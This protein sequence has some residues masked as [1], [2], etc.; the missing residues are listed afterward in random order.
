MTF[1]KKIEI[2]KPS[3]TI[4]HHDG[5]VFLGS[6]FAENIGNLFLANKF[7]T[8]VN[9]FGVLY[10]P[11]SISQAIDILLD[12]RVFTEADIFKNQGVY[13]TFFHHSEFCSPHPDQFLEKINQSAIQSASDLRSANVLFITFGTSYVY[14]LIESGMIVSNCHK[15]AASHFDRYRLS[16]EDIVADW[17]RV[18][19]RLFS[20]NPDLEI[21]MTV[22]PVRH[23]KDGAH[24]NQLS[25]SILLLAIEELL[26]IYSN[27]QYFPAYEIVLDELRDYRFYA[28]DMIHPNNTA[29]QYIWSTFADNFFDD[30]TKSINSQWQNLHR[31]ILHR[32]FNE[33]TEEHQH[34]LEK[35]L[36]KLH[37]FRDNYPHI[38]CEDEIAFL[39]G[40]IRSS[41]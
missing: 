3:F 8:N 30:K 31:A 2:L 20:V 9:P 34:F 16:V 23:W 4:N 32:P 7:R 6:C 13:R 29:I 12:G 5:L 14:R 22:S 38:D 36:S 1:R 33:E 37:L 28:E 35:T 39:E 19:D 26:A 21:V 11:A 40:K 15:I 41:R 10:N 24:N 25:K 18:L 27:I 17:K